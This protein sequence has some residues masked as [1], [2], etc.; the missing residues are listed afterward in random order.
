M[1]R[2]SR[3]RCHRRRGPL[4]EGDEEQAAV[5]KAGSPMIHGAKAR[6]QASPSATEQ[7][8]MS[9]HRFGMISWKS[10]APGRKGGQVADPATTGRVAAIDWNEIAGSCLR[11]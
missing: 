11:A 1:K 3:R 8:C 6:S 5:A 9:W 2:V 10:A 7:S 4:V